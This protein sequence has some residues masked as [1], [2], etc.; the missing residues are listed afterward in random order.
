MEIIVIVPSLTLS[1]SSEWS[2]NE[3][4]MQDDRKKSTRVSLSARPRHS[5]Q[6]TKFDKDDGSPVASPLDSLESVLSWTPGSD[7]LGVPIIPLRDRPSANP[8]HDPSTPKLI[9]CH[10]M[11]GGYTLDRFVQGHRQVTT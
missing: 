4:T 2:G 11:M 10:D 7:E 9:V 1:S 6:T 3:P 8:M 5:D